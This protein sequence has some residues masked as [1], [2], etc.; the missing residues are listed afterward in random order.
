MLALLQVLRISTWL[1]TIHLAAETTF[2]SS[3]K[4]LLHS[5]D[6]ECNRK[7][8]SFSSLVLFGIRRRMLW[9]DLSPMGTDFSSRSPLAVPAGFR[10]ERFLFPST[11]I[12]PRGS[13]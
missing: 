6:A 12:H 13:L 1:V 4:V 10:A 7:K 5:T 3:Q 2:P 8:M 11:S 9:Q